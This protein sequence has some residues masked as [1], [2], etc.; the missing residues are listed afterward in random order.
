[1]IS[2]ITTTKSYGAAS[3][4]AAPITGSIGVRLVNAKA[5][6]PAS[7]CQSPASAGVKPLTST[8]NHKHLISTREA[9]C[10]SFGSGGEITY[11]IV[12]AGP[13]APT[14]DGRPAALHAAA[15][16]LPP[17]L[18]ACCGSRMFWFDKADERAL[19]V[20]KRIEVHPIDIG[21][22]GTKGRSPIVVN[23]DIQADFTD[24]PFADGSFHLVVFDPPHIEREKAKGI[25]TKKYG[26]L[27]GDWRDMLRKG[28]AEC[29]RVLKPHGTL[30]F[31]WAESDHPVSKILELTPER[32]LFGHQSGK[33]SKTHWIAFLKHNTPS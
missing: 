19:F 23:P 10:P 26:H 31:K 17:V 13:L 32:P 2:Y 1:M 21:T 9:G 12:D 14:Q 4:G 28:F 22:P 24:L 5:F 33:T 20:D 15:R 3:L 27:T 30:I 29:F 6:Y 8:P 11:S 16:A 7:A 18:D 25:L